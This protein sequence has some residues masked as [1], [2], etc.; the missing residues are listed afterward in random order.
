MSIYELEARYKDASVWAI[1]RRFVFG[2]NCRSYYAQGY[3]PAPGEAV[4]E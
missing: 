3:S 4:P 1:E 2:D